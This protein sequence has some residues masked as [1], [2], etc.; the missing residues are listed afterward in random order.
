[1]STD[2]SSDNPTAAD[3]LRGLTHLGPLA[4]HGAQRIRELAAQP[5]NWTW[6]DYMVAA[7]IMVLA[8]P[9]SE[10]KTTLLFLIL[11]AR[12]TLGP[13]IEICGRPIKP[14]PPGSFIVLIEAEHGD[15]S[16]ARKLVKSANL[17]G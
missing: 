1:M 8:G 15:L 12:A 2:L 6:Q 4:V 13:P 9:S 3:P 14:A 7:T 16:T 17:L 11:L 5:V 10:G